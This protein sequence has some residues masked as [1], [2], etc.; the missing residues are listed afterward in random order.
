MPNAPYQ[1]TPGA[2]P[3]VVSIPHCGTALPDGLA[4]RLTV[5][6]R[7]LPDT[8]WH[9]PQLYD[10]VAEYGATVI[11]ARYSRYVIDLNRPPDGRSL[12]PDQATTG[13][14]PTTLFDGRPLYRDG[15]EPDDR[16]VAIRL[17][18][19]WHP[20]HM[21]LAGELARIK[22]R[23]GYVLLYDAHSIRS[24]VPRLFD[25]RLPDF[26]LGTA[27]GASL[28]PA[29]R[30]RLVTALSSATAGTGLSSVV[31]GRFVGGHITR[32]YGNPGDGIHAVQMEMTQDI[33][34]QEDGPP[35]A[36]RP[37]RAA[38]ARAILRPILTTLND[39][40]P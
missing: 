9:L 10:F 32:H 36:Y 37:D 38:T 31:D 14:C 39:W 8:D 30:D 20:Y 18:H 7:E 23:F 28:A 27:R 11:A 22:A 15:Q 4:E 12:Y 2:G 33:Y 17:A 1:L 29:L 26:N 35:F 16:E 3:L 40:H 24:T 6:G 25:G 21:A 34:M 5:D 13:L 19:F